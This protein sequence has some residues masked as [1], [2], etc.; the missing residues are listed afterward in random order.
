M[1]SQT[2]SSPSM[3]DKL[4]PSFVASVAYCRRIRRAEMAVSCFQPRELGYRQASRLVADV[5][6]DTY[7][8]HCS[9]FLPFLLSFSARDQ[10]RGALGLRPAGMGPLYLE[11]YLDKPIEQEISGCYRCPVERGQIVEIGNLVARQGGT[12]LFMFAILGTVLQLAGVSWMAFTATPHVADMMDAIHLRT[13]E[14]CRAD[15]SRLTDKESHWGRYYDS[16]PSV[17]VASL[18]DAKEFL[19]DPYIKG[20]VSP[21]TSQLRQMARS[22]RAGAVGGLEQ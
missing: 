15:P 7:D 2:L 22:I 10:L 4:Q 11:Q 19:N 5:F 14:L 18:A 21:Y 8:A 13:F 3:A 9:H 12:G 16:N 6:S 20:L 1:L 17:M